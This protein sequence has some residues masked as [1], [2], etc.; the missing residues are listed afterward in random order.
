MRNSKEYFPG[1]LSMKN[2]FW[3]HVKQSTGCGSDFIKYSAGIGRKPQGLF[4][5]NG[6]FVEFKH[7]L[8]F[9]P[10]VAVHF[11]KFHQSAHGLGVKTNALGLGIYV[12]DV[13]AYALFLF[14]Q[15]VYPVKVGLQTLA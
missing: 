3:F 7:F 8:F 6:G 10:L 9:V 12:F 14:F 11:P 15:A 4:N 1:Q 5:P 13:I 2:N